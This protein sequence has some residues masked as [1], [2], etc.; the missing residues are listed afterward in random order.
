MLHNVSKRS[1]CFGRCKKVWY[2]NGHDNNTICVEEKVISILIIFSVI[3][4]IIFH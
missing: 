4:T 1:L 2:D 3:T